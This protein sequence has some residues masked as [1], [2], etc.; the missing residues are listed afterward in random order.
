MTASDALRQTPAAQR[1]SADQGVAYWSHDLRSGSNWWSPA[2]DG[3]LGN[4][5]A[6]S[7]SGSR[8]LL[9]RI[10]PDDR[11]RL[12]QRLREALH[13]GAGFD[14]ELRLRTATGGWRWA[15]GRCQVWLDQTSLPRQVSGSLKWLSLPDTA[16]QPVAPAAADAVQRTRAR[17]LQQVG[18]EVRRP[19]NALLGMTELALRDTTDGTLHRHLEQARHHGRDLQRLVDDM[20]DL[21]RVESDQLGRR[22][23]AFDL[24]QL[25]ADTFR[26]LMPMAGQRQL[27]LLFDHLGDVRWVLGDEAGV[28]EVVTRLL[29]N[30][31]KFTTRGQVHL[32]ADTHRLCDGRAALRI[33]VADSGP[34]I[35]PDRLASLFQPFAHGHASPAG[36]PQG[37]GLGLAIADSLARAMG[38]RLTVRSTPGG[39]SVFS[40][41]LD[42]PVAQTQAPDDTSPAEPVHCWL[43]MADGPSADWLSRRLHRLGWPVDVWPNLPAALAQARDPANLA[44]DLLLVSAAQLHQT[45][46]MAAIRQALP[47]TRMRVLVRPDWQDPVLDA[48][49]QALNMLPLPVPITPRQLLQLALPDRTSQRLASAADALADLLQGEVLLVEDNEVNQL[50]GL[51]FLKA[52]G[53]RVRLACDGEAALAACLAHPPALVLMDLQMPGINGLQVAQRLQQLQQ[54][55]QWPGAPIIALTAH[56][57]AA[58]QAACRAAGMC[59]VLTKPLSLDLLRRELPRCLAPQTVAG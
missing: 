18:Q 22:H 28:R 52:L 34:G 42:L 55:G 27:R 43:V 51:E 41:W 50:V 40:L 49:A 45:A 57:D 31:L 29:A 11:A 23:R 7:G 26:G 17:L 12:R 59:G 14:L 19:L 13:Q 8:H 54:T 24:P 56:A 6:G 58:D 3:C 5:A 35:A 2:L 47:D 37:A 48:Q 46:T 20:L 32:L 10:H 39:G 1:R 33:D 16:G 36:A 25:L 38:G 4:V 9:R 15:G 53:L 44:P 21:G 30:A